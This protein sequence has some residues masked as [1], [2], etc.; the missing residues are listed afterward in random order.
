MDGVGSGLGSAGGG[1]GRG[2]LVPGAGGST[3]VGAG[4]PKPGK[5]E[6]FKWVYI[7]KLQLNNSLSPFFYGFTHRLWCG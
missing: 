4:G 5:S 2:S 6:I 1:P 7:P 3:G